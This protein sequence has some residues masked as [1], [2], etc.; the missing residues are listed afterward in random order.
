VRLESFTVPTDELESDG[1]LAWDSTTIV[2][3]AGGRETRSTIARAGGAERRSPGTKM[4]RT[5]R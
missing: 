1:T 4:A 2:N 3:V 5:D